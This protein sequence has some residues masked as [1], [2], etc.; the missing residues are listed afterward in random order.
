MKEWNGKVSI[1]L[2]NKIM[3]HITIK[4]RPYAALRYRSL[5]LFFVL[6]FAMVFA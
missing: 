2:K 3:S 4:E 1:Q 5:I 6:R